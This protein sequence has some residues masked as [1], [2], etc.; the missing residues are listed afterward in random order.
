MRASPRTQASKPP[1]WASLLTAVAFLACAAPST[2]PVGAPEQ[3]TPVPTPSGASELPARTRG[4][5]G[6][7]H[8]ARP[9]DHARPAELE[10][11]EGPDRDARRVRALDEW[12]RAA[13]VV[14]WPA[15]SVSARLVLSVSVTNTTQVEARCGTVDGR[16]SSAAVRIDSGRTHVLTSSTRGLGP[17]SPHGI[18]CAIPVAASPFDP[19]QVRRLL[20]MPDGE[21]LV[22]VRREHARA[23]ESETSYVFAGR[24]GAPSVTWR[25]GRAVWFGEEAPR[26]VP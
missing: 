10:R 6:D 22:L 5:E 1:A 11:A 18:Y 3:E 13:L 21:L 9:L 4:Q 15:P 12:A 19:L 2:P 24:T 14:G 20:S 7:G 25:A 16:G 23:R 17:D 26:V 8:V